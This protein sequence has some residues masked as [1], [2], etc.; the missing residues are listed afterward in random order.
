MRVLLMY[1]H[2]DFVLDQKLPKFTLEL[3]KDLELNGII[4]AAAGN[5]TLIRQ[6]FTQAL[7]HSLTEGELIQYRQDI[8]K[9]CLR[10]PEVVRSMYRLANDAL[11]SK[12]RRWMGI[13]GTSANSI[14]RGGRDL[15]EMFW[16]LLKELRAI[17]DEY[18]PKVSSSGFIRLLTMM[19]NELS[20]EY[21]KRVEHHLNALKFQNG[22]IISAELGPGN[23][24]ANYTLL[25]PR[26][27]RRN[28]LKR[29]FLK[30]NP[31]FTYTLPPRDNFGAQVLENLRTRGIY[32]VANAVAQSAEHIESFFI[33]LRKELAF[34]MGCLNLAEKIDQLGEHYCFP[35]FTPMDVPQL[36]FEGLYDLSLALTMKQ[37]IVDNSLDAPSCRLFFISGA[38]QGGKSS[39]L[40]SVGIAQLMLQC[41]LFVPAKK[42]SANLCSGVFSHFK[43]EEDKSMQS[44][45]MEEELL[46][47]S[48]IVD[49]L[50]PYSMV[51]FNESFSATNERE[52]SEIARQV[53]SAL[54]EKNIKVW[55]VTHFY[56]LTQS[57]VQNKKWETL[58]LIAERKQDGTRTFKILPGSPTRTSFGKDLYHLIIEPEAEKTALDLHQIGSI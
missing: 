32:K 54:I 39:F 25:K 7:A 2:E 43:R 21:L 1:P 29:D 56:D 17:A 5:D 49:Q 8:L 4:E 22:V 42:F 33:T 6:V 9:D 58:F 24:G 13:F 14:L 3:F 36:T 23:E 12:K 44:G 27:S 10:F 45:K 18:A 19:Q 35:S 51:L 46:R 37:K 20:D 28:W 52:G 11:D 53:I 26:R 31:Q 34:Y 50:H 38:N 40:R 15:L 30:K 48:A 41:G 57:F 47:M 55:F 16:G